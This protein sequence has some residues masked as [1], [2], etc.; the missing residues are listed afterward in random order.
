MVS[1]TL[2]R[3]W[4]VKFDARKNDRR[5]RLEHFQLPHK[6][7]SSTYLRSCLANYKNGSSELTN[8]LSPNDHEQYLKLGNLN[9]L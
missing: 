9:S 7:I 6:L 4:V 1:L 2:N 3:D 5:I 8:M